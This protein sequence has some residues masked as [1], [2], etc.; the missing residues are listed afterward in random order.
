MQQKP[1]GALPAQLIKELI[2]KGCIKDGQVSHISPA[3]LDLTLSDEIY[4]IRGLILPKVGESIRDLMPLMEAQ[5]FDI[6]KPTKCNSLYLAKLNESLELPEHIYGYCNPKSSTGRLDMHVRVLA[7]GAPRYDSVTP[8]GFTGE[9]WVAIAPK[10]FGIQLH[11]GASLTQLR[12]FTG[13]TRFSRQDLELAMQNGLVWHPQQ[14]RPLEYHELV[15]NDQDGTVVLTALVEEGSCGFEC[16]ANPADVVDI[17]RVGQYESADFFRPITIDDGALRLK[18]N[19]F[20]IL[21]GAER[22]RIPPSLA[23]EM[24]PMDERSGDFRSHYA[25]FLDPGWGYGPDGKGTG[26]PFTLEVRPFED[27]VVRSGQPIAKIRFE[28][29]SEL[30]DFHYDT[31]LSNYLLQ[32]GPK[33]GKHF[34]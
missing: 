4:E 8:R 29:M 15:T 28:R 21:S 26:R 7:D 1:F 9:L 20:Y 30:P 24:V 12:L 13:D 23:S 18:R 31:K 17:A 27:L 32:T 6:E 2:E 34:K 5:P 3:S 16:I 25:G 22:V 11:T 14:N 19:K 10:S 33:L